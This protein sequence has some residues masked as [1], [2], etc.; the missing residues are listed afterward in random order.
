[1]NAKHA[2]HSL[3]LGRLVGL[4][5]LAKYVVNLLDG[6]IPFLSLYVV[7]EL[8]DH[9]VWQNVAMP[10]SVD[11]ILVQIVEL[12][13]MTVVQHVRYFILSSVVVSGRNDASRRLE[14]AMNESYQV[15]DRG[16]DEPAYEE[17][18]EEDDNVPSPLDIENRVE[19]V[20]EQ[21]SLMLG[22]VVHHDVEFASLLNQ[23]WPLLDIKIL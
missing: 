3:L 14:I 4:V 8:V 23:T 16:K 9:I 1:M 12:G 10:Q 2:R 20:A 5:S 15:P 22:H 17:G 21:S 6:L 13:Q 7:H 18:E 19:K 11:I